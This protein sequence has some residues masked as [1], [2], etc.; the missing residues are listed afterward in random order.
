MMVFMQ[1]ESIKGNTYIDFIEPIPPS[2]IA[3]HPRLVEVD[4][5]GHVVDAPEVGLRVPRQDF[6]P[7]DHSLTTTT[8]TTIPETT[9]PRPDISSNT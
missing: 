1:S 2:E 3:E 5:L 8:T 6:L 9:Q 4:Q 7:I